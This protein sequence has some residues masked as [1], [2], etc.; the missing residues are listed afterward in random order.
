MLPRA[1]NA[2][3][4]ECTTCGTLFSDGLLLYRDKRVQGDFCLPIIFKRAAPL[5]VVPVEPSYQVYLHDANKNY[6]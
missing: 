3:E 2:R 1:V 4:L 6:L 5:P